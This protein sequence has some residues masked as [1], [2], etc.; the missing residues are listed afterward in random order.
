M[1]LESEQPAAK[2]TCPVKIAVEKAKSITR[3]PNRS[4]KTPPKNGSKILGIEYNVY[5]KFFK[6]SKWTVSIS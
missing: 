4:T 1:K 5:S 6:N 2:I 3:A